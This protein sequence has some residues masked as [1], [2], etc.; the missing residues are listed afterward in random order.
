MAE[1]AFLKTMKT[2]II[3]KLINYLSEVRVEIK[4][5]NWPSKQDTIKY[6]LIVIFASLIIAIFLGGSDLIFK[7]L[8][9]RFILNKVI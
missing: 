8:I 5:V 9:D 7:F 1:E 2:G 3:Q 4:K 6:T